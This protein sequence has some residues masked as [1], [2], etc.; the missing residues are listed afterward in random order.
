MHLDIK[1][2]SATWL[3]LHAG[4]CAERNSH[5]QGH[6]YIGAHSYT[7]MSNYRDFKVMHKDKLEEGLAWSSGYWSLS[8]FEPSLC[9]LI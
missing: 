1:P 7:H 8:V 6:R 2:N 4:D 3:Q 9:S 5:A